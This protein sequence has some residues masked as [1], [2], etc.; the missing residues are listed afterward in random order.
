MKKVGGTTVTTRIRKLQSKRLRDM[1]TRWDERDELWA[2]AL[3]LT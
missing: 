2:S 3:Y 1:P